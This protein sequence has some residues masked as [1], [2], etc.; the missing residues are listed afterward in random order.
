MELRRL[1]FSRFGM[2]T[3]QYSVRERRLR[4]DWRSGRRRAETRRCT[5]PMSA[6][7][8]VLRMAVLVRTQGS[9]QGKWVY[10][11]GPRCVLGRHAECDI[12]D[13][14]ADN[15]GV[16]RF[17]AQLEC[18]GGR[19]SVEDKGS[20]NGTYVNGQRLTGRAPLRSGDRLGIAGVEL[21]FIEEAE[22]VAPAA[23]AGLSNVSFAEPA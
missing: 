6:L 18:V 19:Y 3:D 12:S 15:P 14:F 13:V 7:Q 17:H 22:A 16:S 10:S 9:H 21:T 8:R 23:A 2:L 4:L 20:R 5:R 11:V 1:F